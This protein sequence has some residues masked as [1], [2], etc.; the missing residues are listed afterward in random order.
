[1][2]LLRL[3]L[4]RDCCRFLVQLFFGAMFSLRC[5]ALLFFSLLLLPRH[6]VKA[7]QYKELVFTFSLSLIILDSNVISKVI[8]AFCCTWMKSSTYMGLQIKFAAEKSQHFFAACGW[9]MLLVAPELDF[10]QP[11]KSYEPCGTRAS[12]WANFDILSLRRTRWLFV[13]KF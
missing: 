4:G 11:G 3:I 5:F 9:K 1:M 6:R 7:E 13:K 2:I 10:K 12:I 8:Q